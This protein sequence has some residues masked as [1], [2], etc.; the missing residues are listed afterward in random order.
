MLGKRNGMIWQCTREGKS[1]PSGETW[2]EML[3]KPGVKGRRQG[4]G[5][6]EERIRGRGALAISKGVTLCP[7]Y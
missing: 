4:G 5:R 2:K 6:G 1:S 7:H 3:H